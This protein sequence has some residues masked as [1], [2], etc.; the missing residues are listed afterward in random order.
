MK[1]TGISQRREYII[2]DPLICEK[3]VNFIRK[4]KPENAMKIHVKPSTLA[5]FNTFATTKCGRRCCRPM[6]ARALVGSVNWHFLLRKHFVI[7]LLS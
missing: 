7:N 1:A 3:V 6:E 4:C 5:N 2:N